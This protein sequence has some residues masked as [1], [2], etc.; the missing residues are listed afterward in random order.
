MQGQVVGTREG[1]LTQMALKGSVASVFPV[2]TSEF[3]R[4]CKLPAAAL[5]RAMI[6]LLSG[7]G[8]KVSLEM[9]ALGIRLV[10]PWVGAR[11][12]GLA[13]ATPRT[14]ASFFG[15]LRGVHALLGKEEVHQL[16]R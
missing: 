15:L 5:P 4:T 2:V 16:R 11:V 9:R 13:F 8:P 6:R 7:V 3:I 10:A 12:R 14:T 1:T